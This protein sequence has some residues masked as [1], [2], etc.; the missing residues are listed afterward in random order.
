MTIHYLEKGYMD[1]LAYS[2]TKL[3]MNDFV[4][5]L[6]PVKNLMIWQEAKATD[7]ANG[8]KIIM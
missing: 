6:R 7:F 4:A 5:A 8:A 2:R 1:I 3:L